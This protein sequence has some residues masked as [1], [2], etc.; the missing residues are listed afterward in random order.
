MEREVY[1]ATYKALTVEMLE[2]AF[3]LAVAKAE[4]RYSEVATLRRKYALMRSKRRVAIEN[5]LGL[6]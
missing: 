2:I 4:L 3:K 1:W 6:S 5:A